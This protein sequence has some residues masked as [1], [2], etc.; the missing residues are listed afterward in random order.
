M[1]KHVAIDGVYPLENAEPALHD[2]PQLE[3]DSSTESLR[4][5]STAL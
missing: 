4:E 3:S 5:R 1:R 2:Q